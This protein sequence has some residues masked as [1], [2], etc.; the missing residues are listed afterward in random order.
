MIEPL[1]YTEKCICPFCAETIKVAAKLCPHCRQWLTMRSFRHP[2]VNLLVVGIPMVLVIV[3]GALALFSS[4]DRLSNPKPNYSEF[5]DSLRILE[6]NMN[7]TVVRGELRVYIAGVLTNTSSVTWKDPEVDCRFFNAKG[8][9]IDAATGFGHVTVGPKDDT[10][11]RV[12]I[13][14]TAPTNSY[15]SFKVS[16]SHARN[17]RGWF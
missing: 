15:T 8:E 4:L 3:F 13:T 6:V 9:M 1:K 17:S 11:F 12:S 7:W 2:L 5:P 16:I 14:P 10:A